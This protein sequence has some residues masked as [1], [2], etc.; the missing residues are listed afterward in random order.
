MP[1]DLY[2]R[3]RRRRRGRIFLLAALTL[4]L[5]GLI[6]WQQGWRPA[7]TLTD[8]SQDVLE[9][10]PLPRLHPQP[11]KPQVEQVALVASE[12]VQNPQS[13]AYAADFYSTNLGD[14]TVPWP[15]IAGRTKVLTY[16]VQPGD[17]LWQIANQFELDLDSLRWSNPALEQNPDLVVIGSVLI[18]LPVPG[19]YHVVTAGD[20]IESIAA[21]YGVS[22]ADI[23][24]YPPNGLYPPY[25]L[26][27]GQGVIVPYGQKD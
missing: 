18:I 9:G 3:P 15:N 25:E 8:L 21:R 7:E 11:A 17:T 23:S 26:E 22:E 1:V 27:P 16:T 12:V 2:V 14:G 13:Q 10:A 20:T 4:L 24:D 6:A 5:A 19:V